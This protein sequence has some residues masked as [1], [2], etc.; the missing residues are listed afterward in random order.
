MINF[1]GTLGEKV[2]VLL[3]LLITVLMTRLD[4]S[5]PFDFVKICEKLFVIKPV[6]VC[7]VVNF[8]S[9]RL[10]LNVMKIL[11]NQGSYVW[12]Q[13]DIIGSFVQGL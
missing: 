8:K 2:D 11:T 10:L 3:S 9:V 6:F 1:P 4:T 12:K 5:Y 7:V 13:R